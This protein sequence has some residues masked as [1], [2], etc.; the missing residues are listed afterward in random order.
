MN[1]QEGQALLSFVKQIG[2]V[3]LNTGRSVMDTSLI[4]VTKEKQI[5]P[6]T[7]VSK[8]CLMLD[9]T[10]DVLQSLLNI[11]LG[12]Y[13]QA[14][15]SAAGFETQVIGAEVKRVL[16]SLN[17]DRSS[18]FGLMGQMIGFEGF[19]ETYEL[20]AENYKWKLPTQSDRLALEASGQPTVTAPSEGGRPSVG[21][22]ASDFQA[23]LNENSNLA[24]GKVITLKMTVPGG[25]GDK[26]KTIEI[27]VNARLAIAVMP[28]QAIEHL[29]TRNDD[30]QNMTER[31]YKWKAGQIEFI[32]DLILC[33]DLIREEKKALMY[34]KHGV[35][36]EIQRRA[37][38]AKAY[39]L[40]TQNPSLNVASNL[41][42]L[43]D[44]NQRVLEQKLVGK[45]ENPRVR[46]VLFENTYAMIICVIN[47]EWERV[48]FYY[49]GIAQPTNVSIKEIKTS[50]KSK[51]PDIMD[52]LK[53]FNLGQ[54]PTF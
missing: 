42:V 3:V 12:Y 10:S 24:V 14:V 26:P 46:Q 27:P 51:G 38:N 48:S 2:T 52:V 1:V 45:L 50:N 54:A 49:R 35:Y 29:L 16:D 44:A 21:V 36:T 13:I 53:L 5:Q 37:A 18:P 11:F 32:K 19:K 7:V 41:F 17:P 31:W 40:L 34:D 20:S 30:S 28:D 15:P 6:L 25:E 8:D 9:Y 39:G 33:Q 23:L 47:R 43:T 22:G 4:D